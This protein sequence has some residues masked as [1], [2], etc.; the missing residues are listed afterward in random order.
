MKIRL[1]I[2]TLLILGFALGANAATTTARV[3]FKP[4]AQV[5]PGSDVLVKDI[6]SI[7]AHRRPWP[8]G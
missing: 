5:Q 7:Q 3:T 8:P 1:T 2:T 4:E 6:A